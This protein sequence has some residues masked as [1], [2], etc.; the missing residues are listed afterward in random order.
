MAASRMS[1]AR[2]L[3]SCIMLRAADRLKPVSSSL[4]TKRL[5]REARLRRGA[6]SQRG[7]PGDNQL[8]PDDQRNRLPKWP[9]VNLV[10]GD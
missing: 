8:D 9:E 10:A 1:V 2:A 5:D 6:L 4:R 7:A 3:T